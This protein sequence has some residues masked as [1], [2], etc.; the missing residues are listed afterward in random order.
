MSG[1]GQKFQAKRIMVVVVGHDDKV[2]GWDVEPGT[3]SWHMTGLQGG[4]TT[5]HIDVDGPMR[6]KTRNLSDLEL[7]ELENQWELEP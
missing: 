2:Q 5:V 3:A 7:P 6:R 1:P 4:R